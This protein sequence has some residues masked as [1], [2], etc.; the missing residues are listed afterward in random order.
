MLPLALKLW[1]LSLGERLPTAANDDS[2]WLGRCVGFDV[3]GPDGR[4][5]T[6]AHIRFGAVDRPDAVVVRSGLFI[7]RFTVIRWEHVDHVERSRR[8]LTLTTLPGA[9][10]G[11]L[12]VGGTSVEPLRVPSIGAEA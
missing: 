7:R 3:Y 6:V 8:R 12:K 9:E 1:T 2:E 4:V 5:G 11:R 10:S